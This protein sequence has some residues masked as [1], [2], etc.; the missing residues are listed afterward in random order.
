MS[1]NCQITLTAYYVPDAV[2]VGGLTIANQVPTVSF[3]SPSSFGA[4]LDRERGG[5][6]SIDGLLW[7]TDA[8]L[9]LGLMAKGFDQFFS[10]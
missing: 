3:D 1:N 8:E 6:F 9:R 4:I 2:D 7:T 5:Y 10:L